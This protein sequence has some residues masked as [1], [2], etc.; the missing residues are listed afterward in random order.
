M[1]ASESAARNIANVIEIHG[2][3]LEVLFDKVV[4][5]TYPSGN[6][7]KDAVAYAPD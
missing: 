5:I 2:S 4:F 6:R 1:G 3:I 7:L